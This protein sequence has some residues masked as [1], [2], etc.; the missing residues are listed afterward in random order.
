[1]FFTPHVTM[2]SVRGAKS[3][4]SAGSVLNMLHPY[5]E[6]LVPLLMLASVGAVRED[7]TPGSK[8][9]N[10][11]VGVTVNDAVNLGVGVPVLVGV[12][13]GIAAAVL[14]EAASAVCTMNV[15]TAP[16]SIAGSGVVTAGAHANISINASSNRDSFVLIRNM[17][18]L[19]YS[20]MIA[21]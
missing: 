5:L 16:G 17:E 9:T 1:M 13:E 8:N 10:V 14:V 20:T 19:V 11:T 2:K 18:V 4:P 6:L 7:E 15:L 3:V 12:A 21:T